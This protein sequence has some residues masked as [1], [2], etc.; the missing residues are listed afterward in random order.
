MLPKKRNAAY[1]FERFVSGFVKFSNGFERFVKG[2]FS[3]FNAG[4]SKFLIELFCENPVVSVLLSVMFCAEIG[5]RFRKKP[6]MR[7]PVATIKGF[8]NNNL[9][10]LSYNRIAYKDLLKYLLR[11]ISHEINE[12]F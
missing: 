5:I 1:H 7:K 11:L 3:I 4:F 12:K 8:F 6:R 10:T 9:T 2:F